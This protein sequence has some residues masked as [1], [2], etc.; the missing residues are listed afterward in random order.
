MGAVVSV[1][2]KENFISFKLFSK[3]L[4]MK[5]MKLTYFN[6]RGR[7]E[8]ARLILSIAGEV[9]EDDRIEFSDW[10]ALKP[11]ER[12]GQLPRLEIDGETLYQS[13]AINRF[14]ARKY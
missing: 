14:L 9:F 2:V 7:A 3:V 8:V 12:F 10:E 5:N 13:L 1:D 6:G 4:E 11:H